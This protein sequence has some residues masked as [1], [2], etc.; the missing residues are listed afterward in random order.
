MKT[1]AK[2]SAALR[3]YAKARLGPDHRVREDEV[4]AYVNGELSGDE[5]ER[6]EEAISLD[7]QAAELARDLA[8]FPEAAARGEEG[9]LSPQ[10]LAHDWEALRARIPR[11]Q[12]VPVV[13]GWARTLR[14]A[15]AASL[16][17]VA[18]LSLWAFFERSGRLET[19]ER[20]AVALAPQINVEPYTLVQA[21]PRGAAPEQPRP[22]R[23]DGGG[24][25]HWLQ[26]VIPGQPSYE[27][28]RLEVRS[29]ERPNQAP[30]WSRDGLKLY[31]NGTFSVA[32]P[33][34]FLAPG[35]YALRIVGLEGEVGRPVAT[36]HIEIPSP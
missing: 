34:A 2:L 5:R 9:Y 35:R 10:D 11:P 12:P 13:P 20:L 24:D 36:Y 28:Y 19:A 29:L 8:T 18:G 25:I 3:S 30:V 27:R 14:F 33:R 15:L 26:L 17:A 1:H 22:I 4:V 21:S 23:L 16:L 32:F 31:P 7:P 6:V